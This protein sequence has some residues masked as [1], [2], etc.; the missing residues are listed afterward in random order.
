MRRLVEQEHRDMLRSLAVALT[1]LCSP[2][3][4]PADNKKKKKQ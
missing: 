1:V 4:L 3:L 2:T